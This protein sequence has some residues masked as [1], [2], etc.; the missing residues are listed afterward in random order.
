MSYFLI[1]DHRFFGFFVHCSVSA[2]GA[3]DYRL[4]SHIFYV[5]QHVVLSAY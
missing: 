1:T 4:A 5:R 3:V 2:I